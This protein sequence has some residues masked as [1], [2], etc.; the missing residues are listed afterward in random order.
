MTDPVNLSLGTLD[1]YY[2]SKSRRNDTAYAPRAGLPILRQLLA[3]RHGVTSEHVAVFA[4]AS[5]A[6]TC[7]FHTTPKDRTV[8][9]PNPGFPAYGGVL[10]LIGRNTARYKLNDEWLTSLEHTLR[11]TKPGALLLNSPGNPLGNV[12]SD[13][14]RE[15]LLDRAPNTL[16]IL[17]ETYAG[18]EF[19]GS[20]SSGALT[21]AAPGVIR[22]GSF[23]KLFAAPGLRIG[24]AVAEPDMI[25]SL[26]DIN[27]LFA[28]S[29]GTA[30]Q[31][32]AA[33]LL[34]EDLKS[35]KRLPQTIARLETACETALSALASHGISASRPSGGPLLWVSFPEAP[36][37]GVALTEYCQQQAGIITTPGEAFGFTKAPAL[38]CSYALPPDDIATV[39]N[40]LGAAMAGWRMAVQSPQLT[41]VS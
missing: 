17:D 3:Q 35:P 22:I 36:G 18:L 7:A 27:W 14:D 29:A 20:G 11:K 25:R 12:I 19:P 30:D 38:R 37:T 26:V 4:G 5:M 24:Y 8:L 1:P 23:S 21:G 31:L 6:L 33:E 2:C 41:P 28:M 39:F 34:I 32:R 16:L 13:K 40:S 15:R 10:D 9:I